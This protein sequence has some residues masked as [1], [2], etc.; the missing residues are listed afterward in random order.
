MH[1][2]GIC[3]QCR[4]LS[5]TKPCKVC[6][7]TGRNLYD[8]VCTSCRSKAKS[9]ETKRYLTEAI[10]DAQKTL[11]LLVE[12]NN[13]M[14]Y[15]AA[16]NPDEVKA[17]KNQL[18]QNIS[19]LNACLSGTPANRL[20]KQMGISS[21]ELEARLQAILKGHTW[22]FADH[23]PEIDVKATGLNICS[24]LE[25]HEILKSELRLYLGYTSAEAI[26]RWPEGKNLPTLQNLYAISQILGISIN[27]LLVTVPA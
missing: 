13:G 22:L 16:A 19:L 18:M 26:Y 11:L 24:R 8:G 15:R 1:P 12:L 5:C 9:K 6:G 20:A 10:V 25:A 27:E 3:S 2:S 4:R 23:C 21:Y 17:V 14:S 7:Q